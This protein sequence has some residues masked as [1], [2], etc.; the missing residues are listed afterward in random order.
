MLPFPLLHEDYQNYDGT[1]KSLVHVAESSGW[2]FSSKK[3]NFKDYGLGIAF[4]SG[5]NVA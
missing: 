1:S 3:Q 4:N 2:K 5:E